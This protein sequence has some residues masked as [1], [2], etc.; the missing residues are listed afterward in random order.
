MK[1]SISVMCAALLVPALAFAQAKT[2]DDYYKAGETAYNLGNFDE[3]IEA[4]K[5]GYEAE[6]DESRK[7][8]YLYNIG[9]AYRQKKDCS[10]A[11][12]F[13]K[14]YLALKDNDQKKPLRADRR[15]VIEDL[16]KEAETCAQQQ[17]ALRNRPPDQNERPGEDPKIEDTSGEGKQL[18]S[19]E[20]DDEDEAEDI[21]DDGSIST[22]TSTAGAT[23]LAVRLGGGGAKLSTGDLDVPVQATGV[24][25]GGYPLRVADKVTLELGVGF[26][27]T[28]VPY[29]Q[30]S[31]MMSK[32]ASIFAVMANVG[33]TYAVSS[34]LGVRGDLGVGGLFLSGV[35]ESPFTDNQPTSGAL[36]MAHVRVGLSADYAL[37]PN[38]LATITPVAFSYSPAKEGL[39]EDIT[40]I[41]AIDFMVGLGYRM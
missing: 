21:D 20:S 37:T 1:R 14:R 39:R 29:E 16:I 31:T 33:A 24:L 9:Q 11:L 38:V 36:G 35:S 41:T 34:K 2:A 23:V 17:E 15:A 30:S 7:A 5:K 27:F 28:P 25:I 19:R 32:T 26:R 10:N 22:S 4:F 8:A 18:A 13:Y 40:S 12:F 3:A 6:P